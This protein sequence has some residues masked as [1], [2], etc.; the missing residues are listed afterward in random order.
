MQVHIPIPALSVESCMQRQA[1]LLE[2]MN[3]RELDAVLIGDPRHVHYYAAYWDRPFFAPLFLMTRDKVR[4]LVI[5]FECDWPTAADIKKTY[6]FNK[7]ATLVEDQLLAS[8][9]AISTELSS[10]KKLGVDFGLRPGLLPD[11]SIEQVDLLPDI[12]KQRRHKYL[13]E[14]D[15]FKRL[16]QTTEAA[17]GYIQEHLRVGMTEVELYAG[18]MEVLANDQ[19]E[20]FGSWKRFSIWSGR[21]ARQTS[22][23]VG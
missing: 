11:S 15:L 21:L 1:Y 16:Y 14:I 9:S 19:G 3:E 10:V 20:H 22:R 4:T 2:L 17:Y 18:M 12:L 8:L 5:P 7:V 23:S 13:D 6:Q